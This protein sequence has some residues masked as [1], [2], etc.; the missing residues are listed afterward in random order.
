[1]KNVVGFMLMREAFVFS[2]HGIFLLTAVTYCLYTCNKLLQICA[3]RYTKL[4]KHQSLLW[5]PYPKF[6]SVYR[7]GYQRTIS[8]GLSGIIIFICYDAHTH[9]YNRSR[10]KIIFWHKPKILLKWL[11]A[12]PA[13][14]LYIVKHDF[15]PPEGILCQ[16]CQHN[17]AF[18]QTGLT[19]VK[20]WI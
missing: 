13:G 10:K 12:A 17:R 8:G 7:A 2:L 3:W 11:Y 5:N 9:H 19:A 4:I 18:Q 20:I 14:V 16:E 15:M 1:M 6:V